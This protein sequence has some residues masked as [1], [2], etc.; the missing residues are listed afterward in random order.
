MNKI[1]KLSSTIELLNPENI[2]ICHNHVIVLQGYSL[3]IYNQ[4]GSLVKEIRF[5][6]NEGKP[7]LL[8]STY[9]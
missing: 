5:L 4:K 6:E 9:N 2:K 8:D 1:K 7:I 3:L